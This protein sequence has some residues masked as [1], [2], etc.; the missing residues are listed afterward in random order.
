[1]S[2]TI[3]AK[4]IISAADATGSVFD[5]IAAKIKG[6]EKN[7]K[8]LEGIKPPRFMGDFN[9]ELQRLKLTE[10]ELQGVRERRQ[11]FM[12]ALRRERPQAQQYF[13][14]Q[15]SL[16]PHRRNCHRCQP[17]RAADVPRISSERR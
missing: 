13:R 8:S 1:M 3:E 10:K 15:N 5:K 14:A 4:A 12:D 16:R 9:A 17:P 11:A 6:L 7:A 2:R